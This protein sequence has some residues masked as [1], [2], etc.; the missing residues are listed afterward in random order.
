[1]IALGFAAT[2]LGVTA[3][4]FAAY[5]THAALSELT[6]TPPGRQDTLFIVAHYHRFLVLGVLGMWAAAAGTLWHVRR[7]R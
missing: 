5:R 2:F 3:G 7:H 4:L 6:T 1:M